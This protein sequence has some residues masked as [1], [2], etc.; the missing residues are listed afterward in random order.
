MFA[1]FVKRWRIRIVQR[2][3]E[4]SI[5]V[6]LVEMQ[7]AAREYQL[8]RHAPVPYKFRAEEALV[9][10]EEGVTV[11]KGILPECPLS[12]LVAVKAELR[13]IKIRMQL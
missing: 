2:K 1:N 10:L 12:V 4:R 7:K 5:L 13:L 8:F 3:L 9:M 6:L 11:L